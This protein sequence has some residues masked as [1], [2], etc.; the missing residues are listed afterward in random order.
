MADDDVDSVKEDTAPNPVSGNVLTNDSDPDGDILTVDQRRDLR[1]GPRL[2]GHQRQWQLRYTLDNSDSAVNALNNGQ[3]LKDTFTYTVSDGHGGTD[4]AKLDI[5]INGTTDNQAPVADDDVDSV[6]EDTAPNPIIGNVLSND[7]DPD[8]DILTVT[9]AGTFDLGHG[10][11]VIH[12]DGT[13]A[14]TLDNSDSA[15]N[16]LNNGQTLKDTFTYTVSD[17]H[18]GTDSAKLDITINGTTDNQAPV[19][20]DDVDS[21]KEDT[22]PNPIVGNVLSNDSDADGDILTVTNAGTFDLGHGSLVIN[23]N[24]SYS[25]T[26][27][28]SDSAVNALNDGQTL[29]DTFTYTVSD[30]HGGTDSA[31][32]DITIQGSTDGGG[33][34]GGGGGCFVA[35]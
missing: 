5:T 22:A 4:S 19:A 18:G 33:G 29:K 11:L 16:A 1:P 27:D 20:D 23:A 10:S 13:Y 2:P 32:L 21:V 7:S 28:N 15:V 14:Y 17:G 9:N 34:G 25:Y 6:K 35:C 24:G 8:G 26:L 30:G 3:T 31:K 12:A